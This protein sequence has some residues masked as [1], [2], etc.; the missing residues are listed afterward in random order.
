VQ[1]HR[2]HRVLPLAGR[3]ERRVSSPAVALAVLGGLAGSVQVAVM[4]RFGDRVGVMEALAFST[5]IQLGVAAIVVVAMEPADVTSASFWLSFCCVAAIFALVPALE[6]C[7]GSIT[8]PHRLREALI[9]TV[10]TQIGT[11]PITAAVFLQFSPYAILA[12]L[13]VIPCVPL[14]MTLGVAQLATAWCAPLAQMFANLNSWAIAWMLGAVRTLAAA[15]NASVIMTPAPLWAIALYEGSLVP[16]VGMLRRGGA[17]PAAAL[18]VVATS[19]VLAPPR[20]DS[21]QLR[22]TVL[23]VGQADAIAVQTPGGHVRLVE[24]V[25]SWEGYVRL[26]FD[27]SGKL[28]RGRMTAD[29]HPGQRPR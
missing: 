13:V 22:I 21:H 20:L 18:I 24:R 25:M 11:W 7:L 23:D 17:T 28:A 5:A 26:A 14:T 12:N 19:F 6:R 27:E 16:C 3:P 10:A 15:P 9:L 8:M 2:G 29:L 1:G 4:G